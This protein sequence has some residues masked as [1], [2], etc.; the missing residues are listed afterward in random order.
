M[1][2]KIIDLAH[3]NDLNPDQLTSFAD[4]YYKKYD[5]SGPDGLEEIKIDSSK[6]D[7]LIKDF[8]HD[9]RKGHDWRDQDQLQELLKELKELNDMKKINEDVAI[10]DP[11]LMQQYAS[12]QK[13]LLDKDTQI[14]ALQKQV[15]D[16][17]NAKIPIQKA[18]AEIEQ[19]A[20]VAQ[21]QKEA[22]TLAQQAKTQPQPGTDQSSV[23]PP[24]NESI[25]ISDNNPSLL[26]ELYDEYAYLKINGSKEELTSICKRIQEA[27]NE[28]INIDVTNPMATDSFY[29]LSEAYVELVGQEKRDENNY[30]ENDYVF[31]VK[32]DD[33]KNN[34]IGKIYKVSPDGEWFGHVKK[35]N[36]DTF[37][38]ISYDPEYDEMDIIKFLGKTYNKVEII[39]KL[40]Y[41]EFIE[42]DMEESWPSNSIASS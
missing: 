12:G 19:K 15:A 31:Y 37:E 20:G 33:G 24:P 17:Q 23:I 7:Q 32:I 30:I 27:K 1:K 25:L 5:I 18:M 3:K 9:N 42:D 29:D 28:K 14:N 40:N 41:N 38:K 6:A 36:S 26:E 10:T 11:A 22:E 39:D 4:H 35:G 2:I 13:Q 34:F 8:N 16:I 21:Q